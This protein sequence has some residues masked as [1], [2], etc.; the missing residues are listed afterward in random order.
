MRFDEPWRPRT[1]PDS[2]RLGPALSGG[3]FCESKHKTAQKPGEAGRFK[4]KRREQHKNLKE[5]WQIYTNVNNMSASQR[6][7]CPP[8]VRGRHLF[9][10]YA[11]HGPLSHPPVP[12]HYVKSLGLFVWERA[13]KAEKLIITTSL[14]QKT[15]WR[16][17]HSA[18]WHFQGCATGPHHSRAWVRLHTHTHT[19]TGQPSHMHTH[20]RISLLTHTPT[21]QPSHKCTLTHIQYGSAATETRTHRHTH[22]HT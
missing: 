16:S 5:R 1:A 9:G 2:T 15:D 3:R 13:L 10:A 12:K 22:T 14:P 20:L 21:G 8:V 11:I 19:H 4:E 18:P 7:V 6:D 17:P